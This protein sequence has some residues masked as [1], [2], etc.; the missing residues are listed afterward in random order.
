LSRGV[1]GLTLENL[2]ELPTRCR[3]CVFWELAPGPGRGG[4]DDAAFEK[5]AWLS[6]VLLHWGSCGQLAYAD[7]ISAG[8][9]CYAP[10]GF[11]PRAAEFPTAPVTPDAI[12]LTAVRVLP[13]YAAS[14]LGR[15]LVSSVVR[16][17]SRRGVR[18]L[19]AFGETDPG[20]RSSCVIPAEFLRS[21]GFRTLRAHERWPLLRMDIEDDLSWK[22]DVEE[23]LERLLGSVHV[24]GDAGRAS[25]AVS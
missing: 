18:A 22:E 19:E 4:C 2:A 7:G 12:L 1:V 15:L 5:E 25:I 14:G 11:V 13:A 20:E 6:A 8:Y 3:T 9:A 24:T 16:D 21:V 23:A 10:P 17:L